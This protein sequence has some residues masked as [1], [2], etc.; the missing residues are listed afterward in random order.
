M[1]GDKQQPSTPGTPAETQ[2]APEPAATWA[3]KSNNTAPQAAPSTATV[4]QVPASQPI[5]HWT[6]SEFV[7]HQKSLAWYGIL[8]ISTIVSAGLIYVLTRGDKITALVVIVAALFFG[9][10]AGRKPRTLQY[11]INES[12]ITIGRHFYPY[13]TFKS[14]WVEHQATFGSVSFMPL[15]RFMPLLTVYYS[16]EEEEAILNALSAHLP[17]EEPHRD[18]LDHFIDR[19]RF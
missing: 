14:F 9:Y 5:V 13:E 2:K 8:A 15:K 16:A 3:F 17:V 10:V 4:P 6:A 18:M 7:A 11:E 1:N 19:I 12:G